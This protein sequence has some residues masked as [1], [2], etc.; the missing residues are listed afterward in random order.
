MRYLIGRTDEGG[1]H[2]AMDGVADHLAQKE[3]S[4]PPPGQLCNRDWRVQKR[5]THSA[6]LTTRTGWEFL[7]LLDDGERGHRYHNYPQC[8]FASLVGIGRRKESAGRSISGS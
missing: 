1:V 2:D 3:S 5:A 7:Q 6:Q 4:L 8:K